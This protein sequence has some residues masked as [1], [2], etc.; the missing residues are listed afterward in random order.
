MTIRDFAN[1]V[2]QDWND[3]IKVMQDEGLINKTNDSII[4]YYLPL[5]IINNGEFSSSIPGYT[6]NLGDGIRFLFNSSTDEVHRSLFGCGILSAGGPDVEGYDYLADANVKQRKENAKVIQKRL[7]SGD[8]S[9]QAQ[10]LYTSM[11]DQMEKFGD[12]H[13]YDRWSH[14]VFAIGT[15]SDYADARLAH[16]PMFC[17]DDADLLDIVYNFDQKQLNLD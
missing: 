8:F 1:F 4:N 10:K 6:A 17:R 7:L 15:N 13:R 9:L 12:K 14:L 11:T 3:K 2:R 16:K 5:R